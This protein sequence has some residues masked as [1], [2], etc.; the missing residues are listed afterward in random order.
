MADLT[1]LQAAFVREYAANPLDG[2]AAYVRAGGSKRRAKQGA[3][4]MLKVPAVAEAIKA[5]M[6][7]HEERA[8]RRADRSADDVR[9]DIEKATR[10]AFRAKSL[11]HI[12]KGLELEGKVHGIF[13]EKRELSGP[14]G[15]PLAPPTIIEEHV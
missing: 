4:E 14:G 9:R 5:A 11:G 8:V 6:K 7:R 3:S 1:T 13:V 10:M 2:A 12:F 15:A